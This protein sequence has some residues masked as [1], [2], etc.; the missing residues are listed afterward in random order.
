MFR[1]FIHYGIHFIVPIAIGL[2]FFKENRETAIIILLAGILIDIDHLLASPIF[3]PNRC[4]IDFHPLHTYWA[5]GIYVALLFFKK[6]RIFGIALLIHIL[7]DLVDC[8][9]LLGR[10]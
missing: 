4:S 2:L 3:D 8:Y 6:T 5:I 10:W 9:L 1:F 7:A